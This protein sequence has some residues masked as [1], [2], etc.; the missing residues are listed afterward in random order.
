MVQGNTEETLS[1]KNQG[2][3]QR[4]GSAVRAGNALAEGRE[5]SS[6]HPWVVH[7]LQQ[8]QL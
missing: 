2:G 4:A 5:F 6:Q 7:K 8:L 1:Q 3:E